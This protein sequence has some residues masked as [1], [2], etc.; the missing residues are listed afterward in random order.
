M[1]HGFPPLL[2]EVVEFP[3]LEILD[4]ALRDMV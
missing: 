3:F 1:F 2:R 4:V